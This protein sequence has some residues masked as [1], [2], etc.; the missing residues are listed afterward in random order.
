MI[1]AEFVK[2]CVTAITSQSSY[3]ISCR[4]LVVQ[5][6]ESRSREESITEMST[7]TVQTPRA[8]DKG[9]SK[10]VEENKYVV[11]TKVQTLPPVVVEEPLAEPTASHQ[12]TSSV[13]KS[14]APPPPPYLPSDPRYELEAQLHALQPMMEESIAETRSRTQSSVSPQSKSNLN[15]PTLDSAS[16]TPNATMLAG[17][18]I[19]GYIDVLSS[20]QHHDYEYAPA[21]APKKPQ[22]DPADHMYEVINDPRP[23]VPAPRM[24]KVKEE[25]PVIGLYEQ[26]VPGD[27]EEPHVMYER[28]EDAENAE[29]QMYELP[30]A[31]KHDGNALTVE[32]VASDVAPP[33]QRDVDEV[34]LERHDDNDEADHARPASVVEHDM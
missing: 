16:L 3:D 9:K 27:A 20:E 10:R 23:P 5:S 30:E 8:S 2:R 25:E 4:K 19:A 6:L 12:S 7:F 18:S 13:S 31:Q 34:V 29:R 26:P 22:S 28:K 14:F 11:E 21:P 33:Q 32:L 15:L 24:S 17:K 1:I